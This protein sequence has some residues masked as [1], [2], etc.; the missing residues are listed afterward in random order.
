MSWGIAAFLVG[1]ASALVSAYWA[2]GGLVGLDTVGG[3]LEEMGR[4]RDPAVVALGWAAAG[5][6]LLVATLGLAVAWPW[7][8]RLP[9]RLLLTAA[10]GA[11]AV[12]VLYGGGLVVGQALVK[13]GVIEASPDI[14]WKAFH[15]HL[16]FWD[17][18]FLLWG[19]LLGAATWR[20][21]RS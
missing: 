8:R 3:T 21:T 12:L 20:F 15:W 11:S 9:R 17:P 1:L 2:A 14:D 4:A 19:L 16:Y 13:V 7:G 18:W 5:A 6:K 10:W